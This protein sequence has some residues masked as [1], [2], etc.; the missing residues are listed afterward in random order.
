MGISPNVAQCGFPCQHVDCR[1]KNPRC[2]ACGSMKV[3]ILVVAGFFALLALRLLILGGWFNF[4]G[5]ISAVPPAIG[6]CAW[7]S[8][9]T[10]R[11]TAPGHGRLDYLHLTSGD[12]CLANFP[13]LVSSGLED[14]PIP[15]TSRRENSERDQPLRASLV[16]Q[17]QVG[18]DW[19]ALPCLVLELL[20][21]GTNLHPVSFCLR[22]ISRG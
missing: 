20:L 13:A 3:L 9:R 7:M 12:N 19:E 6:V 10:Q 4:G 2:F 11:S 21:S 14:P 5:A 15:G 8:A 1:K 17:W 22:E 16:G 18:E